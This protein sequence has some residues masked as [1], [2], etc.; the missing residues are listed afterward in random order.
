MHCKEGLSLAIY[1]SDFAMSMDS[2]E[3]AKA[4]FCDSVMRE[5][6]TFDAWKCSRLNPNGKCEDKKMM[7]SVEVMLNGKDDADER[8]EYMSQNC[9]L[10]PLV[11]ISLIGGCDTTASKIDAYRNALTITP[12][13]TASE[14]TIV[15]NFPSGHRVSAGECEVSISPAGKEDWRNLL[16]ESKVNRSTFEMTSTVTIKLTADEAKSDLDVKVKYESF[17]QTGHS[18]RKFFDVDKSFSIPK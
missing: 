1:C 7:N 17:L 15:V 12:K 6:T 10:I 5:S 2:T 16:V 13:R 11:V 4:G 8:K 9:L 14:V 3:S 18:S